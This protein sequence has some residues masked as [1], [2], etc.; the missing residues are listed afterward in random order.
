MKGETGRG[1]LAAIAYFVAAAAF[2]GGVALV[3]LAVHEDNDRCHY[4]GGAWDKGDIMRGC[5]AIAAGMALRAAVRMW[6]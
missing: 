1:I 6:H 2:G 5:A 3:L 4:Y